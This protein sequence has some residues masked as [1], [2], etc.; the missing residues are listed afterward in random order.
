LAILRVIG[1]LQLGQFGVDATN[2]STPDRAKRTLVVELP[3][4]NSASR[5]P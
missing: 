3:M 1:F 4:L 5:L 2:V